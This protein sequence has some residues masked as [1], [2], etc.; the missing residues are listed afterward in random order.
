MVS[1]W[2]IEVFWINEFVEP[3][4]VVTVRRLHVAVVIGIWRA[5]LGVFAIF[6]LVPKKKITN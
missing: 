2:A 4:C 1:H 3:I 5:A 6:M